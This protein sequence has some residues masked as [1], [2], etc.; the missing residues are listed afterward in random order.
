MK[1][2]CIGDWKDCERNK[3]DLTLITPVII[4][5]TKKKLDQTKGFEA[6]FGEEEEIDKL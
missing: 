4:S 3:E 1:K 6:L 2:Y 5:Q